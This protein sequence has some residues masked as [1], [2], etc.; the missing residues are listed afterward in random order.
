MGTL[1]AWFYSNLVQ[2]NNVVFLTK[3][4]IFVK[5]DG[6]MTSQNVITVLED[7][8]F[9]KRPS[10]KVLPWQQQRIYTQAFTF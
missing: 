8:V 5:I 2:R 3:L 6:E 1:T 4:Q 10:K 9:P 7:S